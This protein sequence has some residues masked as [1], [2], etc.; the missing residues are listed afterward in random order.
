MRLKYENAIINGRLIPA[1]TAFMYI[2]DLSDIRRVIRSSRIC[3]FFSSVHPMPVKAIQTSN[4]P[5]NSSVTSRDVLKKVL[6]KISQAL[7]T[8]NNVRATKEM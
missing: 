8:T 7:R 5:E 6:I 2:L 1:R 4:Q 3:L